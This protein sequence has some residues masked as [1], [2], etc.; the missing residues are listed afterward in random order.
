MKTLGFLLLFTGCAGVLMAKPPVPEI[1]PGSMAS[2]LV[3][4]G[5]GLAVLR[6]RRKR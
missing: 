5:G 4:L 3:L 2:A 1:D 6:S